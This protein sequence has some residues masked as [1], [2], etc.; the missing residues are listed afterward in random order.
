MVIEITQIMKLSN[1]K[2]A[3]FDYEK[4]TQQVPARDRKFSE[5]HE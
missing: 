5:N 3:R 1:R 4:A 2:Y